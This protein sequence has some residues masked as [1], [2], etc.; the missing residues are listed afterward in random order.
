ML[1]KCPECGRQ[2][3][4]KAPVCPHCGIEIAPPDGI[5][6]VEGEPLEK[7]SADIEGHKEI[8]VTATPIEESAG[9]TKQSKLSKENKPRKGCSTLVISFF[10]AS[11]LLGTLLYFYKDAIGK[12]KKES[13]P[14]LVL[15]TDTL[16]TDSQAEETNEI[17]TIPHQDTIPVEFPIIEEHKTIINEEPKEKKEVEEKKVT[18]EEK[19]STNSKEV[20][21]ESVQKEIS[22]INDGEKQKAFMSVRRFF[23]AINSRNANAVRANTSSHMTS[24]GALSNATSEDVIN[25]MNSLY[26]KDVTNLNFHLGTVT[27]IKKREVGDGKFEYDL[28]LPAR[29]VTERGQE[30]SET[31]YKIKATIATDGKVKAMTINQE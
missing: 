24:F 3:S 10:I 14:A 21:K 15:Q 1:I 22:T 17:A 6:I 29:R 28:A 31:K 30:K 5:P 27:S 4:D 2:V 9:T 26:A 8:I 19:S 23:Q 18:A 7:A 25:Y 16:N 13:E 11:L 12:Q 20:I